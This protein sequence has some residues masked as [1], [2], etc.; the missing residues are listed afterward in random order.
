MPEEEGAD[1]SLEKAGDK[2]TI[3]AELRN[4]RA[5]M[6]VNEW[7][8]GSCLIAEK[9]VQL[10][11]FRRAGSV[12]L[13]LCM[14]ERREVDTAPL[15][16]RIAAE[17]G[18]RMYIPFSC[19]K[20][21]CAVPFGKDDPVVSGRFGQPEPVYHEA[22][23]QEMPDIVIVPAVAVD[24]EGRRLGYGKGY[25]DRFVSGLRE[26]DDNP[27]VIAFVFSFQLLDALPQDPWDERLD[28]IVTEK[29]VIRISKP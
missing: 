25:Y 8:S 14:N 27:L 13:Y 11:E 18:I 6:D 24:R 3:R 17:K 4:V 16:S 1:S 23:V 5:A 2:D 26:Q 9:T 28:C 7:R 15:I 10:P 12:M 20:D 29:E 22:G 21:L 19:G